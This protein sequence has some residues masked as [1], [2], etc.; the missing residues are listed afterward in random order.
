MLYFRRRSQLLS[1]VRE[2]PQDRLDAD[3]DRS[4]AIR[5]RCFA[6]GSTRAGVVNQKYRSERLRR[7]N[8]R[9]SRW[10]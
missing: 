1:C 10:V 3:L 7:E 8:V 5:S 6:G 4:Y 2:A 9:R